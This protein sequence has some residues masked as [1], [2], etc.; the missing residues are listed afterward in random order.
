MGI[1]PPVVIPDRVSGTWG[2][3]FSELSVRLEI[4]RG[5]QTVFW[6]KSAS[7]GEQDG[8]MGESYPLVQSQKR[9]NWQAQEGEKSDIIGEEVWVKR[10]N[11]TQKGV[12]YTYRQLDYTHPLFASAASFLGRNQ[13]LLGIEKLRASV[14]RL[15]FFL[16]KSKDQ[17]RS[18]HHQF[19]SERNGFSIDCKA[20][21]TC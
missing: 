15:Q 7:T 19:W 10:C 5:T 1:F 11:K 16:L 8:S 12:R 9:C 21:T 6:R 14:A 17:H 4:E 3:W 13:I 18:L 20:G 2:T